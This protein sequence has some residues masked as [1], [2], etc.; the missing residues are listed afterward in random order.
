MKIYKLDLQLFAEG[1]GAGASAAGGADGGAEGQGVTANPKQKSD[2]VYGIQEDESSQDTT[3][4]ESDPSKEFDELIKG[5]YKDEYSRRVKA[6]IDDRFKAAN[7]IKEKQKALDPMLNLLADKYGV[8]AGDYDALSKA[9]QDDDSFYEEAALE[10]GLTVKQFKEIRRLERENEQ[11]QKAQREAAAQA[12]Q[13][14]IYDQ[15]LRDADVLQQKYGLQGFSLEE[16][17]RN[18]DFLRLLESGV[19]I[20]SAYKAIHFDDMVGGAMAQTANTVRKQIAQSVGSRASRPQEGG[21]MTQSATT[22]K[23][24]VKALTKEDRAEII[25]RAARGETIRF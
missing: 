12:Q 24:D 6:A 18:P 23:T 2:V 25:R 8:D 17:A 9:I 14:Q 13:K 4:P 20:E 7:A 19:G 11:L 15:W 3:G 1:G 5:Q 21:V 10:A 16:E 22:F